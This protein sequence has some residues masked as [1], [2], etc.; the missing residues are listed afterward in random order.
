MNSFKGIKQCVSGQQLKKSQIKDFCSHKF[1]FDSTDTTLHIRRTVGLDI[2]DTISEK[3]RD[4]ECQRVDW[5]RA[6]RDSTNTNTDGNTNTNTNTSSLSEQPS[7]SS[8]G[9]GRVRWSN[10]HGNQ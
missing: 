10:D 2:F 9:G 5:R 3:L 7:D 1:G 6:I 8:D 4:I